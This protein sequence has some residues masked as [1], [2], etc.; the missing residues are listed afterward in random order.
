MKKKIL[1]G[2]MA[3]LLPLATWAADELTVTVTGTGEG[4]AIV[5]AGDN[6]Q[7]N[8]KV[9]VMDKA[10]KKPLDVT[11]YSIYY[12]RQGSESD[13]TVRNV[14]NYV[15]HVQD[16]RTGKRAQTGTANFE[17][18]KKM[19]GKLTVAE[20]VSREYGAGDQ[21]VLNSLVTGAE[22]LEPG[23]SSAAE[24]ANFLKCLEVGRSSDSSTDTI[25][26]SGYRVTVREMAKHTSNYGY[27]P[28]GYST[29]NVPLEITAKKITINLGKK[30]YDGTTT[31][32][33]A[34][35]SAYDF[36]KVLVG[37][38]VVTLKLTPTVAT[39]E[40]KNADTYKFTAKLDGTDAKNYVLTTSEVSYQIEKLTLKI[41]QKTGEV[42]SENYAGKRDSIE[43]TNKFDFNGL[44]SAPTAETKES[45]KLSLYAAVNGGNVG[46][47][48]DINLY[49]DKNK[50]TTL[51]NYNVKYVDSKDK[52]TKYT[53][54]IT[55]KEFGNGAGF[56]ILWDEKWLTYQGG[57]FDI[58][59]S[60]ITITYN[61]TDTLRYG[62][63]YKLEVIDSVMPLNAGST[64]RVK[65]TAESGN[66]KGT[67]NSNVMTVKKADLT[68]TAKE[69]AVLWK[70]YDG[71]AMQ[72]DVT[73]QFKYDGFVA[74]ED[75]TTINLKM[76]K[77]FYDANVG[78]Y[79]V[80]VFNG[81]KLV[82]EAPFTNYNIIYDPEAIFTI[83]NKEVTYHIE[84]DTV[85][86]RGDYTYPTTMTI[87][88]KVVVDG[89]EEYTFETEPTVVLAD[90]TLTSVTNVGS[91]DL[92]V[93]NQKDVKL[94][95]FALTYDSSSNKPFVIAPA[96]VHIQA[97]VLEPLEFGD[98]L[99]V[100][101]LED[102]VKDYKQTKFTNYIEEIPY[103][104][105]RLAVRRM[106]ELQLSDSA[107]TYKSGTYEVGLMIVEKDTATLSDADK[108]LRGNFNILP[109]HSP[110][111]IK[112]LG[113]LVLDGNVDTLSTTLKGYYGATVDSVVVKNLRS[114]RDKG[115]LAEQW[116]TLVLPFNVTVREL[117][118]LFGYA[119]VNVPN[120][121]NTDP[122]K[123]LFQLTM[124]EIPANTLMAFKVDKDMNWE[125]IADKIVFRNKEIVAPTGEWATDVAGN[126]FIGVYDKTHLDSENDYFL[127]PVGTVF[128]Q[129]TGKYATDI[130][131][132]S[133]YF[134]FETP[135]NRGMIIL[136]NGDGSTTAIKVVNADVNKT[137]EGWYTVGGVKLE[138]EP[139]QKGVYINN[140]KKVVI[141]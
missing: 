79:K 120:K 90:T 38:D 82:T 131:P 30:P 134:H 116:Y 45:L 14:G 119:I 31:T 96:D 125:E 3:M 121:N 48:Y 69:D 15:A 33:E 98:T 73:N 59:D 25:V 93:S 51:T 91:Y 50:V 88:Y 16:L 137:S 70:F 27:D 111:T 37:S 77:E 13:V 68:I 22:G 85:M 89:L 65:A 6:T 136:D 19:L 1:F 106:I 80:K 20:K 12:T 47:N 29:V 11:E 41:S 84:G 8:L 43:V 138:G 9:T 55:Q 86:Y 102:L 24:L 34:L 117:S 28:A 52:D 17:V 2:L 21:V 66:F 67:M 107:K 36:T 46:K 81:S 18:T 10:D 126:Q 110:L 23:T 140:G 113:N 130:Y 72:D 4:G 124:Q 5:Y 64:F 56:R 35:A 42:L 53:Y 7:G 54:E 62:I 114:I 101:Q 60:L 49:Q 122:E 132:L 71:K 83:K 92:T 129:A 95:N 87:A 40:I 127:W 63:D 123:I 133:G 78:T 103:D 75:T 104:N 135:T 105:D 109:I 26:G 44:L 58:P 128:H 99:T 112:G 39:K 57:G 108:L 141:K 100:K 74:E 61:N 118:N 139:T 94:K 76:K 97:P 115:V 32:A